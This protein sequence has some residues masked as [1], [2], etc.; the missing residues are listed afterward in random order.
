MSANGR[1][2]LVC[3]QPPSENPWMSA[4]GKAVARFLPAPETPPDPRAPGPFAFAEESYLKGILTQTGF[5]D[6]SI[7]SHPESAKVADAVDEAVH[8]QTRLGPA[9]RAINELVDEQRAGALAAVKE[10]LMPFDQGRGVFMDAAVWLVSA[11][12]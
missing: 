9:S 2:L 6:V 12:V 7:D 4:A 8:F 3:W 10:A 5:S 11:K 1:L